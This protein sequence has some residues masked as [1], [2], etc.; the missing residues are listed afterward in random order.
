MTS[1][2]FW[3]YFWVLLFTTSKHYFLPL[4]LG[5]GWVR[6][7]SQW[8]IRYL[9]KFMW[10]SLKT[11]YIMYS[12]HKHCV[13]TYLSCMCE[14]CG[15]SPHWLLFSQVKYLGKSHWYTWMSFLERYMIQIFHR[16][17]SRMQYALIETHIL[18]ISVHEYHF[19]AVDSI[20]PF[21]SVCEVHQHHPYT[22]NSHSWVWQV[23]LSCFLDGC[24]LYMGH[25]LYVLD[26]IDMKYFI[27]VR[28]M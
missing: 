5:M 23:T 18:L 14:I 27:L 25:Y 12:V 2:H 24:Q 1:Y 21:V 17:L 26:K 20:I 16:Y 3:H 10:S 9:V 7:T 15:C 22:L 13:H 11:G 28:H 19:V 4:L 8:D 6:Y